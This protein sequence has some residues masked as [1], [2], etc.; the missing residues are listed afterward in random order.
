MT[1]KTVKTFEKVNQKLIEYKDMETSPERHIFLLH[2]I[3]SATTLMGGERPI[4]V[5]GGAVECYTG[6]RFATGDLDLVAPDLKITSQAL[7][8]LGYIRPAGS[9]HYVNRSI[10]SL[11]DVH[12]S[13]LYSDEEPVEIIYRQV[14]LLVISPEDCLTQRLASYKRHGSTLDILNAFLILYHQRDRIDEVRVVKRINQANLWDF[15]RPVQDIGRALVINDIGPDEAA[16][17]LIQFMKKG[18][19]QCAF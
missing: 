9:K 16:A 6:V 4:M 5:G 2:I 17:A 1:V 12:S 18:E 15:Y 7:E 14:P 10:A 19:K 8:K 13:R 3:T 11:V